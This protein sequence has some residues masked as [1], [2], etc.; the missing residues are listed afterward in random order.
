MTREELRETAR[1]LPERDCAAQGIEPVC[2]DPAMVAE[3][4][5]L[6]RPAPKWLRRPEGGEA[7]GAA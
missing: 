6:L 7:D 2:T 5:V 4:A 3:V 1:R